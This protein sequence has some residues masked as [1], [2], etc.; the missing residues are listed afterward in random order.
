ML[1]HELEDG[2]RL[3]NT[4]YKASIIQ[5]PKSAKDRAVK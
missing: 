4:F 1:F 5:I 3:Q 2:R